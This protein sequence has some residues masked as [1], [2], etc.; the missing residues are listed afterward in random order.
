VNDRRV[1][2]VSLSPEGKHRCTEL[3]AVSDEG[4]EH[5]LSLLSEREAVTLNRLLAKLQQRL[6][7][8]EGDRRAP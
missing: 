8:N 1:V 5:L 2:R 4:N 3:D 6:E 7:A